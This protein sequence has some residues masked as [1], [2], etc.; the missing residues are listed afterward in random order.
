MTLQ[1]KVEL[2]RLASPDGINN[3]DGDL[4]NRRSA[5]SETEPDPY[6][7]VSEIQIQQS[8]SPPT[9]LVQD[10]EQEETEGGG[11]E[12]QHPFDIIVV[13][14]VT[15]RLETEG[16][17]I[18][19]NVDKSNIAIADLG[20]NRVDLGYVYIQCE[21][22]AGGLPT[23]TA[24]VQVSNTVLEEVE[25]SGSDQTYANYFIGEVR[26]NVEGTFLDTSQ[27]SN[28][29]AMLAR[30]FDSGDL[31]WTFIDYPSHPSS[32]TAGT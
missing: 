19:N 4:A 21:I 28:E 30:S 17:S 7:Y 3:P 15:W 18:T 12:F 6:P 1:E 26:Q 24:T 16:S 32:L 29:A 20:I 8:S 23:G 13:D 27:A 25:F 5:V 31:V 2:M 10:I 11:S 9:P 22:S 14:E